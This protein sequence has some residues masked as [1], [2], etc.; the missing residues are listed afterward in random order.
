MYALGLAI[1]AQLVVTAVIPREHLDLCWSSSPHELLQTDRPQMDRSRL[2]SSG[3]DDRSM[4][5]VQMREHFIWS[6][7]E[8]RGTLARPVEADAQP[9]ACKPRQPSFDERL[10]AY[11]SWTELRERRN[12]GYHALDT[13]STRPERHRPSTVGSARGG[14][15][16]VIFN[17]PY[18]SFRTGFPVE[19][20][21]MSCTDPHGQKLAQPVALLDR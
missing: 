8:A 16:T 15:A 4:R 14:D 11:L 6:E 18:R 12:C 9:V 17:R 10:S 13:G 20:V 21:C 3:F 5:H 19:R 1:G 2:Q 7:V